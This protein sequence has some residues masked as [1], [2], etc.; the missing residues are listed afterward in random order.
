MDK[1]KAKLKSLVP[2]FHQQN[3]EHLNPYYTFQDYRQ[4]WGLTDFYP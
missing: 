4:I 1:V 3:D 2:H